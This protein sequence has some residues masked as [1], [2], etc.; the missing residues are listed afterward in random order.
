[1]PSSRATHRLAGLAG[2][3]G[4]LLFF[5]GDMLF[6]GHFGAG[7]TF[8]QGV[9]RVVR[10]ASLARLI[11]ERSHFGVASDRTSG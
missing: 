10:E 2:L 11:R 6:Y 3:T 5:C 9:E 8:H 1:M 4:A 7:A